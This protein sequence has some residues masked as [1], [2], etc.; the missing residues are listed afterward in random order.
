M[1][2]KSNT[3]SDMDNK[4][5]C[6]IKTSNCKGYEYTDIKVPEPGDGELL[7]KVILVSMCGSDIVL[8]NWDKVGR[9]IASLPF[10]PGH[11]C[12]AEIVHTGPNCTSEFVV[13]ARVCC[14]NHFYCGMCYQCQ[15]D[16]K[17]ICQNMSQYGHGKGTMHGGF[18][19]FSII[20]AKY[21]Y[22]LKTGLNSELACLLEPF[23]VSHQGVEM[24]SPKDET[25]LI[26][27]CG[28]IGLYAVALCKYFGANKII[29]TDVVE[30]RLELAKSLGADVL[31]DGKRED[32][33]ERVF[34][35]T[36]N[37][38]VGCLLEA[39][40]AQPLVNNCFQMLRKGGTVVLIGIPKSPLHVENVGRDVLFKSLTLHTVHGRKIFSTWE[41][42]EQLLAE[43]KID[44]SCTIS[45][46]Y[47]MSQFEEAFK[48][49]L[50]G[51]GCKILIDPHS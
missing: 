10:I 38:G 48:T 13:G 15:N 51:S 39:S 25:V 32:L 21:A 1:S 28:P 50:S 3:M 18:S 16:Q 8:Y 30:C 5:K 37:D 35:E 27:G 11:E 41:K 9:S 31:V 12:V 46:R 23:G 2:S 24:L 36:N 29:A 40:G 34:M 4:M 47:G 19:Q 49:L 22:I 7:V 45:S 44:I 43:K 20:P 17:H 6:I 42:C 33:K 26:Q 14:E